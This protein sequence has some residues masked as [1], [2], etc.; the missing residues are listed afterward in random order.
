M[1]VHLF[2]WPYNVWIHHSA[3]PQLGSWQEANVGKSMFDPFWSWRKLTANWMRYDALKSFGGSARCPTS[4]LRGSILSA[5]V[6][7]T[8]AFHTCTDLWYLISYDIECNHMPPWMFCGK[9]GTELTTS[10]DEPS[11]QL[12]LLPALLRFQLHRRQLQ[13]KVPSVEKGLNRTFTAKTDRICQRQTCQEAFPCISASRLW[14]LSSRA[15]RFLRRHR[16]TVSG[17]F[18]AGPR[19]LST[20]FMVLGN[21]NNRAITPLSNWVWPRRWIT[22]RGEDSHFARGETWPH[23]TTGL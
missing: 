22:H 15:R 11:C 18:F 10:P 13:G 8:P 6:V 5:P 7:A 12:L 1:T 20:D 4:K 21:S 2:V 19:R 17:Q 14:I 16:R 23:L 3:S 9:A